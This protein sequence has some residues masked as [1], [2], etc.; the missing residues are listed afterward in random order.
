MAH[1]NREFVKKYHRA[2]VK[3]V[4]DNLEKVKSRIGSVWAEDFRKHVGK[5]LKGE[6]FNQ[7]FEDYLRDELGFSD[8]VKVVGNEEG[9]AIEVKGCHLCHGNEELRREG[10]PSMCPVVPTGLI[11][12]HRVRGDKARLQEV[13]KNGVVGE[14]EIHYHVG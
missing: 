11:S 7:A 10:D 2:V 14:C 13:R 9:L 4:S 8:H 5:K 6:E 1:V 3:S 12:L